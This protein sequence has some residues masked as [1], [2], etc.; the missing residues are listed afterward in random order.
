MFL[1]QFRAV[2]DAVI[3]DHAGLEFKKA[4]GEDILRPVLL[5][6]A[7][8]VGDAI[9]SRKRLAA[10]ALGR[11]L[12]V[13]GLDEAGKAGAVVSAVRRLGL[14]SCHEEYRAGCRTQKLRFQHSGTPWF[15]A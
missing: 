14:S 10:Q 9:E 5:D 6:D 12:L 11:G 2:L 7:W 8:V 4:L 13:K 1:D 15:F 3:G